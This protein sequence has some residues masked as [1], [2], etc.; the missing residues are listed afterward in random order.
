MKNF[1]EMQGKDIF[2]DDGESL[3]AVTAVLYD[4]VCGRCVVETSD[5]TFAGK[6][7]SREHKLV[8]TSGVTQTNFDVGGEVKSLYKI[9]DKQPVYDTNG[10]YLGELSCVEVNSNL[11]VRKL[12]LQD[13]AEIKRSQIACVGEI[14]LV[15]VKS[16]KRIVQEKARQ[17]RLQELQ[18]Q[19]SQQQLLQTLMRGAQ[20]EQTNTAIA[21]NL[22][23][24]SDAVVVPDDGTNDITTV[25][26]YDKQAQAVSVGNVTASKIRRAYGDFN[27]LI[28]K[29]VD[30][31]VVNFQGEVMI[32]QHETVTK[33]I[34][35]QAK[36]SGKLLELYLHIE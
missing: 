8:A 19:Q 4:N 27:F 21:E 3:G 22:Q 9:F 36:V 20:T 17:E 32:R 11:A 18:K 16:V 31:T 29:T 5:N 2:A 14:V 10:K 25:E 34:L 15:K 28:G 6:L 12:V 13:G 26:E 23:E 35:R 1:L 7:T 24:T 30:K 33:D